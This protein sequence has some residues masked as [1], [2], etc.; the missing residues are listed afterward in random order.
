LALEPLVLVAGERGQ[1]FELALTLL[2]TRRLW[3]HQRDVSQTLQTANG[4]LVA[5]FDVHVRS[6]A[7]SVTMGTRN[8][9]I[10]RRISAARCNLLSSIRGAGR[11]SRPWS[12]RCA[13]WRRRRRWP[14][15]RRRGSHRIRRASGCPAS[16]PACSWR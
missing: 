15:D 16:W 4:T 1:L 2:V 6:V 14:S 11:S 3:R 5:V 7:P 8:D 10:A 13:A 12:R 9:L